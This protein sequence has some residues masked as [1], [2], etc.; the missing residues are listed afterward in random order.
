MWFHCNQCGFE[1]M[2]MWGQVQGH[3]CRQCERGTMQPGR[4]PE[5]GFQQVQ[6]F[7][8]PS[9][10]FNDGMPMEGL[11]A[12]A[13]W[14][15]T[16]GGTTNTNYFA[17]SVGKDYKEYIKRRT[18]YVEEFNAYK[19][20][21]HDQCAWLSPYTGNKHNRTV[22]THL[23]LSAVARRIKQVRGEFPCL[24]EPFVGSGQIFLN[25]FLSVAQFNEGRPLFW[26]MIGGD[27]NPY[28]IA[29]YHSMLEFKEDFVTQYGV[30]A[31][32]CDT[33]ALTSFTSALSW[34]EQYGE[35]YATQGTAQQKCGAAWRYIYVVNR[36]LRGSKLGDASKVVA[37]VDP[38]KLK[39]LSDIRQREQA[40]LKTVV[41]VLIKEQCQFARCDFEQTCLK[42]TKNDLVVMDCPFPKFSAV[43]PNHLETGFQSSM[44]L[45]E[46]AGNTYGVCNDGG[47]LQQRMITVA[48]TLANRGV[49]VIL[50]NFANPILIEAYQRLMTGLPSEEKRKLTFVYKSPAT[51]SEAYQL[52]IIPGAQLSMAGIGQEICSSWA[53][54]TQEVLLEEQGSNLNVL[55]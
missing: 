1:K 4:A 14:T 51:A 37:N 17:G 25:S 11:D 32:N 23:V 6:G 8:F 42:A 38:A 49:T 36:C 18:L 31:N 34:L 15:V 13:T 9:V 52:T 5:R 16:Q 43:V 10:P 24:I 44:V 30:F 40:T 53:T 55:F 47:G 19:L 45:S 39:K 46:T 29:A 54:L 33:G 35:L 22:F 7:K 28:V 27:L 26:G 48:Q 41:G 12:S 20:P 3:P 50:C 2:Y 21:K